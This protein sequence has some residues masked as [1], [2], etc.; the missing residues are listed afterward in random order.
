MLHNQTKFVRV[1]DAKQNW[2]LFDAKDL[3]VGRLA[4]E[5][6]KILRGKHKANFTPNIDNGDF[7]V[8]INAKHVHLTGTKLRDDMY[9]W[10]T[11]YPGGLKERSQGELLNGNHP[12]RVMENAVRRMMPKTRLGVKQLAK[13]R[14]YAEATHPHEAQNPKKIEFATKNAKNAKRG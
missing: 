2:V 7:V 5:V 13:L 12:E 6:A 4:A 11:G 8:I 10:H 14:V 3:V 1:E 9:R